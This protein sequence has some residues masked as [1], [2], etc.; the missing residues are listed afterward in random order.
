[1]AK[2]KEKVVEPRQL[3]CQA[4]HANCCSA[5]RKLRPSSR[6]QARCRFTRQLEN[7]VRGVLEFLSP[8]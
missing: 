5:S 3:L 1:M 7:P 2:W 8:I 4:R 6:S